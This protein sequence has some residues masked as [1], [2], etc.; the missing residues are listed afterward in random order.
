[1]LTKP[2][3]VWCVSRPDGLPVGHS[4]DAAS[5]WADI[6]QKYGQSQAYLERQGYRCERRLLVKKGETFTDGVDAC[7]KWLVKNRW[8]GE[9]GKVLRNLRALSPAPEPNEADKLLR[10][11]ED[12]IETMSWQE[13]AARDK[14]LAK[15][16]QAYLKERG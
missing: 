10:A 1:M 7:I 11:L 16:V 13:N 14:D 15:R 2:V 4:D 12:E 8:F 5:A 9:G 3:E 6:C